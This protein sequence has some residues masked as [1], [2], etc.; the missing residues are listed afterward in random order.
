MSKSE[1]LFRLNLADHA[2]FS[3][4][5]QT[6]LPDCYQH[7]VL[8]HPDHAKLMPAAL[9]PA[10]G[11]PSDS[12]KQAAGFC[13]RQ[14]YPIPDAP[15][16]GTVMSGIHHVTAFARNAAANLAFYRD[17]LGL[18]LVKTTVNFDDPGTYHL[19]FGDHAGAPGTILTFFPQEHAAPGRAGVGQAVETSFAIPEA[20]LGWWTQRLIAQGVA[21]DAPEKRFGQT[22][23]PFKDREELNLALV[24]TPSGAAI[25]GTMDNDVP[26]QHA[27]RGVH[28]VT[29]WVAT[30]EASAGV[31]TGALGFIASGFEG[32]RHRFAAPGAAIGGVVDLRVVGGFLPARMGAG[33]VHHVAFRAADDADQ[34]RMAGIL[35][36]QFGIAVTEQ[37]DRQYFRSVY[38]RE[39]SGVIFEI[40]TDDPGFATDEPIEALG[41]SL[42]LP[43]WLEPHRGEIEVALPKLGIRPQPQLV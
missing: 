39:P 10:S 43:P 30:P 41:Q 26:A 8:S 37:K 40:A 20:S 12:M 36:G 6:E 38:F 33:T 19:Y 14:M 17:V 27:I 28:G 35:G 4:T 16:Q 31:L 13:A 5:D 34:A 25:P 7:H 22:V 15:D 2:W 18:R 9:W 3:R 32:D 21:H 29:I 24:A 23:L 11:T 1:L 42:K